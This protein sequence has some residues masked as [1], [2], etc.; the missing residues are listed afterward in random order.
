MGTRHGAPPINEVASFLLQYDPQATDQLRAQG[1]LFNELLQYGVPAGVEDK[2]A[3]SAEMVA[4]CEILQV[5]LTS[6]REHSALR[7]RFLQ[8]KLLL[9]RRRRFQALVATSTGA[10]IASVSAIVGGDVV[11]VAASLLTLLASI[12]NGTVETLVL[13]KKGDEAEVANLIKSLESTSLFAQLTV[14]Y[15]A[16]VKEGK[17]PEGETATLIQEANQQFAQLVATLAA[18]A[19]Y[20]PAAADRPSLAQPVVSPAR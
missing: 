17:Y 13:G 11:T 20:F 3:V 10:A 19:A 2:P 18:V 1:P 7:S 6:A 15:L 4:R 12:L 16:A 8:A 9:V 14:R 5:A